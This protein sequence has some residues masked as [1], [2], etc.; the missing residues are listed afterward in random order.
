MSKRFLKSEKT[1]EITITI[2]KKTLKTLRKV[3]DM[4]CVKAEDM[5]SNEAD[6]LA[7]RLKIKALEMKK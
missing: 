3:E 2:S 1:V 7:D 6:I 5:L 4:Y